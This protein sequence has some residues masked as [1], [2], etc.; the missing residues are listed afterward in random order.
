MLIIILVA[1]FFIFVLNS[2]SEPVWPC[3]FHV[4]LTIL[5]TWQYIVL[6]TKNSTVKR[7]Y[8][9]RYVIQKK[10]QNNK[11]WIACSLCHSFQKRPS[12]RKPEEKSPTECDIC[13]AKFSYQ[14]SLR[15]H[16]LSQH[17]VINHRCSE[18][19]AGFTTALYLCQHLKSQHGVV[20]QSPTP[21]PV[22]VLIK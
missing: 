12:V 16:K 22:S 15:P 1:I 2:L 6:R 20:S 9:K 10:K 7:G 14:K 3:Y 13:G 21:K 18:C 17:K 19:P 5:I 8:K 11:K 4:V